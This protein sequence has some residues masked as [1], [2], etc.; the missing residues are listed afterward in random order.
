MSHIVEKLAM[1][2][3]YCSRLKGSAGVRVYVSPILSKHSCNLAK[4]NVLIYTQ[5]TL[6][7]GQFF[8]QNHSCVRTVSK[9][10]SEISGHSPHLKAIILLTE[11]SI[12]IFL[13]LT[14]VI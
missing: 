7:F 10:K 6:G 12:Q 3:I 13:S 1:I 9:R 11:T 2:D 14:Y 5:S 4:I 8:F